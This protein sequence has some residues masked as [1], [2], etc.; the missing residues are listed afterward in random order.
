MNQCKGCNASV[1]VSEEEIKRSIE[2]FTGNK[3]ISLVSQEDYASRLALCRACDGLAYDTTC[4]NS[5][6]LMP[7]IAW[8]ADKHCPKPGGSEW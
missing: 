5:G 7:V 3:D 4:R 8:V 1:R 6:A 2:A